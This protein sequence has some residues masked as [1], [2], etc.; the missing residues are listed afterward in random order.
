MYD[1]ILAFIKFN[2]FGTRHL[3]QPRNLF[4]SFCCTS[5]CIFEPLSVYELGFNTDKYG[6]LIYFYILLI[7]DL[8]NLVSLFAAT[9]R[10]RMSS[11]QLRHAI[12]RDY[13]VN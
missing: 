10:L 2:N 4:H 7:P 13:S 12:S 6:K 11:D 3:I 5:R 1:T 8:I 9:L